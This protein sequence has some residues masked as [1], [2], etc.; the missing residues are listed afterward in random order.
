M[1][2]FLGLWIDRFRA[3]A[4]EQALTPEAASPDE[5]WRK[6]APSLVPV[7][8]HAGQDAG[9]ASDKETVRRPMKAA[10]SPDHAPSLDKLEQAIASGLAWLDRHMAKRSYWDAAEFMHHEEPQNFTC[11]CSGIGN[12]M[13]DK[14]LTGLCLLA[15]LSDGHTIRSGR[16]K[17]TVL[18]VIRW[19]RDEQDHESGWFKEAGIDGQS[20]LTL[21][22]LETCTVTESPAIGRTAR[23]C[24][25]SLASAPA[26]FRGWHW[27]P[28]ATL[29]HPA[30]AT[31][32]LAL[33]S[34]GARKASIP[35]SPWLLECTRSWFESLRRAQTK[36]R[37]DFA[38]ASALLA[39]LALEQGEEESPL[40]GMAEGL[41]EHLPE[42]NPN[43]H[44]IDLEA[45]F[46]S[47]CALYQVGRP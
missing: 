18:S 44:T 25:K 31:P 27:F 42:W 28:S 8:P 47:S 4:S 35:A 30:N 9:A 36:D 46:L 5:K 32:W 7:R 23:L 37:I 12:S 16:Y 24:L 15:F 29:N 2:L 41:F 11:E 20:I 13:G 34:R 33:V 14:R 39:G 6:D 19:I 43:S 21:A 17:S 26:E 38:R 10:P 3:K 22:I 40:R 1:S 45:W